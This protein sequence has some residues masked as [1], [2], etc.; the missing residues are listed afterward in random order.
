MTHKSSSWSQSLRPPIALL[1]LFCAKTKCDLLFCHTF[2]TLIL[3]DLHAFKIFC[4]AFKFKVT[5]K[6]FFPEKQGPSNQPFFVFYQDRRFTITDLV[7]SYM[8]TKH[9]SNS[10][11]LNILLNVRES[12]RTIKNTYLAHKRIRIWETCNCRC[13]KV[14]KN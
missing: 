11:A 14:P 12:K 9:N 8:Y 2:C 6:S 1:F 5:D 10:K 3:S 7:V 13:M 4:L